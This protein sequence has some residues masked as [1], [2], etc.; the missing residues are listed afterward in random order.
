[1]AGNTAGLGTYPSAP[2]RENTYRDR[3]LAQLRAK[4]ERTLRRA[5]ERQS[6]LD[7]WI[8]DRLASGQRVKSGAWERAAIRRAHGRDNE[9]SM[10]PWP[11]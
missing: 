7:L 3:Q 8:N 4:Y 1:M 5:E 10:T 9:L 6:K 11:E 2:L